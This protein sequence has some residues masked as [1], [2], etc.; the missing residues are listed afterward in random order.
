MK[1]PVS[2]RRLGKVPGKVMMVQVPC[3]P[4][5]STKSQE[6]L[7]A[8]DRTSPVACWPRTFTQLARTVLVGGVRTIGSIPHVEHVP[9][10]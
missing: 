9:G 5:I 7:H 8:V 4:G 3:V 1:P 10:V 2:V 6:A